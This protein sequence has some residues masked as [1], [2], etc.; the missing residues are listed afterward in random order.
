MKNEWDSLKELNGSCF[1]A[2]WWVLNSRINS[3]KSKCN[4]Q[5][6]VNNFA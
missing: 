6:N 2:S 1:D 4:K 3:N 5:K